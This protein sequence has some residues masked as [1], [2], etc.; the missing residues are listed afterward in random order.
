[1]AKR[2]I[3]YFIYN[4]I[5][6]PILILATP[7]FIIRNLA[8]RRPV[9]SYFF[10]VSRLQKAEL[11]GKQ[12]I[13]VQ[14][15]SV[16]ETFIAESIIREL[17]KLYPDYQIVLTTT[18]P[19]GQQ[20]A[21]EKMGDQALV[22]YFPMEFPFLMKRFIN[23]IHPLLFVMVESEIWPNAVYYCKKAG[24]KIAVVNGRIGNRSYENYSK[25]K[26]FMKIVLEQFDLFAMQSVND[27]NRIGNLGAPLERIMVMGN[28]KFDQ[29]Y[30][31]FSGEQLDAFRQ[32]YR[33]NKETLLFTAASTHPGEEAIVLEAYR[34]LLKTERAYLI[35]APRHPNRADE[36]AALLEQSHF[37]YARRSTGKVVHPNV[38]G[39]S[40]TQEARECR[41][42]LLDTFGELGLAYAVADVVLVGGSLVS[43]KGTAGH[44]VLEAAVQEKP[45]IYGPFMDN[46]LESKRLLEEVDAGFTVQNAAELTKTI[47]DLVKNRDQYQQR[48]MR[49]KQAVLANRGATKRTIALIEDLLRGNVG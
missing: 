39:P 1:V 25:F 36:V 42:L 26:G 31:A 13:W 38:S 22:T 15:V 40:V 14:A 27:A 4:I 5:A 17:K 16:G 37:S 35:I 12:V 6:C 29:E 23:Q 18:T 46:F 48:A 30:P 32:Q 45:V 20:I 28:A 24:T 8:L 43:M 9:L 34:N 10:N 11:E 3:A 19:T 33:F 7:F 41:V 21:K 49:A 47:L 44:N 2:K